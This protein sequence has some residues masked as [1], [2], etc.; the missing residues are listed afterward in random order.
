MTNED[1][2]FIHKAFSRRMTIPVNGLPFVIQQFDYKRVPKFGDFAPV[3]T[4][5]GA[6]IPK[7]AEFD[8]D[9]VVTIHLITVMY[10]G[11][12]NKRAN[13]TIEGDADYVAG[14]IKSFVGIGG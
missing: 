14:L 11:G 6:E 4:S 2:A 13:M 9:T 5:D 3:F 7:R 12:P 1:L 10:V 8:L